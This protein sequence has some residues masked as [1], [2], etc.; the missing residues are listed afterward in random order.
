[1]FVYNDD[2]SI[3]AVV[4]KPIDSLSNK[5][6]TKLNTSTDGKNKKFGKL[7]S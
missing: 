3:A 1:M 6:P 5:T 2:G 7:S 4:D